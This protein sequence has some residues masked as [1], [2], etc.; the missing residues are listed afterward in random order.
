MHT[1][2]D[3]FTSFGVWLTLLLGYF[4]IHIERV[5]TFIVGIFILRIG[6][7][8]FVKAISFLNLPE[9]LKSYSKKKLSEKAQRNIKKISNLFKNLIF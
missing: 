7:N 8:M 6:I 3:F 4:S 5:M 2:S 1:Y 9:L